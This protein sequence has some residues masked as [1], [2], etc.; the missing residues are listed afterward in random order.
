MI[1][2]KMRYELEKNTKPKS[3]TNFNKARNEE[4]QFQESFHCNSATSDKKKKSS[5]SQKDNIFL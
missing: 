3:M 1:I 5:H 2:L 4:L